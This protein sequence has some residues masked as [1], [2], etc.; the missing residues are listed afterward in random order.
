M[1]AAHAAE[2]YKSVG[3][4]GTV[5][6]TDQPGPNRKKVHL[7]EITIVP[8]PPPAPDLQQG[9]NS[10][11]NPSAPASSSVYDLFAIAHP[12]ENQTI[13]DNT[14]N[15]AVRLDIRPALRKGD[16]IQVYLDGQA[17]GDPGTSTSRTLPNVDRGSHNVTAVVLDSKGEEVARAGP[18][19]FFLHRASLLINPSAPNAAPKAPTAPAATPAPNVPKPPSG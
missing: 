19:T 3:P 12:E 13:R 8:S 18:V 4:D 17:A 6:Y 7:P 14:G 1:F 5:T 2:V 16:E 15:V 9:T 11:Q 10:G